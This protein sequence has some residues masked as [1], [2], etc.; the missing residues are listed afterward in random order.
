MGLGKKHKKFSKLLGRYGKTAKEGDSNKNRNELTEKTLPP[1][2]ALPEG[3]FV[4]MTRGTKGQCRF[5]DE[6]LWNG[7][8]R[9][10][11][12]YRRVRLTWREGTNG[13]KKVRNRKREGL[14]GSLNSRKKWRGTWT[15]GGMEKKRK[16]KGRKGLEKR[17]STIGHKLV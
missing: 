8:A 17:R 12:Q 3:K 5:G 1:I 13:E 11:Q 6:P 4:A 15:L 9:R 2:A 10:N 16:G 14:P 7:R